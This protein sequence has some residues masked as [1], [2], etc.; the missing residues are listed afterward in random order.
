[1]R[2]TPMI[3]F[4]GQARHRA[5]VCVVAAASLAACAADGG[6]ADESVDESSVEQA[7]A[8]VAP[9]GVQVTNVTASGSGCPSGSWRASVSDDGSRVTVAFRRFFGKAKSTKNCKVSIDVEGRDGY[10]YAPATVHLSGS[11][12]ASVIYS[13]GLRW[14]GTSDT[15]TLKA[16]AAGTFERSFFAYDFWSPCGEEQ[17]LHVTSEAASK[18]SQNEFELSEE[19]VTFRSRRCDGA[20]EPTPSEP[21]PRP[22]G[23]EQTPPKPDG[24]E[25]T[26]PKPDGGEQTPPKPDGGEQTPTNPTTSPAVTIAGANTAGAGCPAGTTKVV[27]A[28]D[29]KALSLSFENLNASRSPACSITLQIEAPAG[30][31]YALAGFTATGQANLAAGAA[32]RLLINTAYTGLGVDLAKEKI[33]EIPGPVSGTVKIEEELSSSQLN[34]SPC[35]GTNPSLRLSVRPTLAGDGSGSFQ[36]TQIDS[37]KFAVRSCE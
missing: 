20:A 24:G 25:Q 10:Q 32:A 3:R 12:D 27:L 34:F 26:P 35:D 4:D 33:R 15:R 31:S 18:T 16:D 1:M 30:Q 22:D 37:L 7:A 11:S 17:R 36:L 21:K 14:S 6:P 2:R 8:L 23:G 29:G 19:V 28:P 9:G 5:M 13:A